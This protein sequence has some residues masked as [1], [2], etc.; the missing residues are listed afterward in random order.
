MFFNI[1]ITSNVFT[2]SAMLIFIASILI[3]SNVYSAAH[4]PVFSSGPETIYRGGF[5]LE[6]NFELFRP[7]SGNKIN[8]SNE[9]DII[10]G[11]RENI[12]IL[13]SLPYSIS[14]DG[15][16]D[17]GF[18]NLSLRMK[19]RF[20]KKD[21][22]G[23][24]Y[25]ATL[26]GGATLPKDFINN[27]NVIKDGVVNSFIGVSVGYESRKWYY[28]ATTKFVNSENEF[29]VKSDI[30]TNDFT[31]G[32]RPKRTG[33][34]KSDLVLFAEINTS[35][36]LNGSKSN[37][38][39]KAD[40]RNSILAGPTFLWSKRNVMIKGG[41]QYQLLKN[42]NSIQNRVKYRSTLGIEYHF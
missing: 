23:A 35:R 30:L 31:F 19:Y 25:K 4:D 22:F 37:G 38:I 5:G 39:D 10:Y 14:N 41:F 8:T 29:G 15:S 40:G 36:S 28:F 1:Y 3:N 42:K 26:M 16:E 17:T 32:L 34:Y 2:R 33:F 6:S 12:S 11:L 27:A 24:S 18:E 13:A 7:Y 21:K 9:I 20:F